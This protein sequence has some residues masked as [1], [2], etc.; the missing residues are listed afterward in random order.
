MN[1]YIQ[2]TSQTEINCQ[3]KIIGKQVQ[4]GRYNYDQKIL[5]TP[6][7]TDCFSFEKKL[8]KTI[9][10]PKLFFFFYLS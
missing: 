6:K 4:S 10:W 2:W 7:K 5:F 1:L 3:L 8:K 9:N